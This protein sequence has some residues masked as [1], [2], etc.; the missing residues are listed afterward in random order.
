[1]VAIKSPIQTWSIIIKSLELTRWVHVWKRQAVQLESKL[2]YLTIMLEPLGG[3]PGDSVIHLF[4]PLSARKGWLATL[5]H[6]LE[7]LFIHG[8]TEV[9]GLLYKRFELANKCVTFWVSSRCVLPVMIPF[10]MP[11]SWVLW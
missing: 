10:W 6:R 5:T 11:R 8:F 9:V 2:T 7:K 3:D 4:R 1:M